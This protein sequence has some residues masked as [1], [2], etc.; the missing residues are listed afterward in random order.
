MPRTYLFGRLRAPYPIDPI[1]NVMEGTV[2]FPIR[3]LLAALLIVPVACTRNE[4]RR[5]QAAS[6][7]TN[8]EQMKNE[9]NAYVKSVDSRLAEF[10]QKFDGLDK[11]AN[12][13][14]GT[15]KTNFKN[16][17]DGLRDER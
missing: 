5:T 14:T 11:R 9:R 4:P 15:A 3:L 13:M 17:I 6:E 2:R 10:D 1:C 12:A 16:A 7:P 8:T